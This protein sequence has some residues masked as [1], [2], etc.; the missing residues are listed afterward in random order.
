MKVVIDTSS[1]L[2]LVR[3]YLPFDKNKILYD[4]IKSKVVSKEILVLDKVYDECYYTAKGIVVNTLTYLNEKKNLIKTTD[5]LPN[6]KFFNQ[7][8]NQFINGSV[9]NKL[10]DTEFENRKNE[11][12]ESADTK[13]LLYSLYNRNEGIV[14]VSEET[15]AINDNK[16]FKKLPAICK[17]LELEIITL[18][19]FLESSDGI[20][21]EF[22]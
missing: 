22:S 2:S 5:I 8:E 11:F 12:L 21:F 9:K 3:Y 7:L 18:P 10:S 1:L 19:E 15:E 16:S 17:I 14:I 6:Q 13:L 4:F 20:Y